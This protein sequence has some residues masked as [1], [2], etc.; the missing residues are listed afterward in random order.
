M[1]S[2]GLL[3]ASEIKFDAPW[4]EINLTEA[5]N[6]I[7]LCNKCGNH[8]TLKP[9]LSVSEYVDMLKVFKMAHWECGQENK[10]GKK[11]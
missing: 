4:V 9:D 8:Y 2:H 3:K 5:G 1:A 6:N 11:N 10:D 7:Y